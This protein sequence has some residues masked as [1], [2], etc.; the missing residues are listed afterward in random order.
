MYFDLENCLLR[1]IIFINAS[2]VNASKGKKSLIKRESKEIF[3]LFMKIS[4][5]FQQ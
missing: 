3:E 5:N 1:V 2:K 4:K